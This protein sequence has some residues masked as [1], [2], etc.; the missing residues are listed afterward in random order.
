MKI[1][2]GTSVLLTQPTVPFFVHFVQYLVSYLVSSVC[3][4]PAGN[5]A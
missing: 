1:L 3:R 5:K 4:L 2:V